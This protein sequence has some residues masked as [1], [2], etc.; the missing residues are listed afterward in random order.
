MLARTHSYWSSYTFVL[1]NIYDVI[2]KMKKKYIRIIDL[3][4]NKDIG[5]VKKLK[6]KI[7]RGEKGL[8]DRLLIDR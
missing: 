8:I 5:A 1:E 6:Y 3:D 4:L 2:I 7:N